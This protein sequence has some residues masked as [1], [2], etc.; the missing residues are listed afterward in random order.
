MMLSS[1]QVLAAG[2][3]GD[4][5]IELE[6]NGAVVATYDQIGD[7]ANSGQFV[8]LEYST[9]DLIA[10]DNVRIN[11]TN[12]LYDPDNGIDRNVRIDAIVIDGQR[13]ETEG[14]DV[15]STSTWLPEDGIVPGFRQ[16]DTIHANGYLQYAGDA[17]VPTDRL[18]L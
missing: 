8:Q 4:E 13:F 16:S 18:T 12:D 10:A 5:I 11:F 2:T 7:G 15:F 3:T 17:V 1:V 6:V 14:P 9:S